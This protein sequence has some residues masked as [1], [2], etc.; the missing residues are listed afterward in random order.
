M[1][2]S[3]HA[4]LIDGATRALLCDPTE[5]RP[6]GGGDPIVVPAMVEEPVEAIGA[7]FTGSPVLQATIEV[8]ISDHPLRKG[9][10]AIPGRMI[11]GVFVAGPKG[12]RV[13]GGATRTGDGRWQTASIER[14]TIAP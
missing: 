14:F 4:A 13:T 6:V 3:D 2:F 10:I 1:G 9:D 12:W 5:I 8:L 11:D 7:G